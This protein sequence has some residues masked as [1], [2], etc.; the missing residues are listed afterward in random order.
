MGY[1]LQRVSAPGTVVLSC[2]DLGLADVRPGDEMLGMT[3]ALLAA[4]AGTVVASVTRVGDE[5]N[6]RL[7][8]SK[9]CTRPWSRAFP[10]PPPWPGPWPAGRRVRVLRG[11]LTR[12]RSKH[13]DFRPS[14]LARDPHRTAGVVGQAAPGDDRF[15][16]VLGMAPQW[17]EA[18]EP[19][20][21]LPAHR[22]AAARLAG[23]ARRARNLIARRRAGFPGP[24]LLHGHPQGLPEIT[25]WADAPGRG[26]A[27]H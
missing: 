2:C 1:D 24:F 26:S 18:K 21:P 8:S 23:P 20:G 27:S 15:R 3:T 5:C 19:R 11:G 17:P 9:T 7:P 16:M 6:W 14:P 12:P 13:G 10:R 22:G 25:A 4:G